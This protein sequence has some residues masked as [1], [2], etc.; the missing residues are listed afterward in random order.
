MFRRGRTTVG[1]GEVS[2]GAIA[3]GDVAIAADLARSAWE[4]CLALARAATDRVSW[5][6]VDFVLFLF[7]H[8]RIPVIGKGIMGRAACG[9]RAIRGSGIGRR[10]SR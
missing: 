2:F 8:N 1:A 6:N 3:A 10:R 4:T 5:H 9:D 7:L